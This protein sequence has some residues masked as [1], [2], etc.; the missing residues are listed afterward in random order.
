[1]ALKS[2]AL[3]PGF[4]K[5]LVSQEKNN[6]C[7]H[8]GNAWIFSS[9]SHSKRNCNK[10]H[11]MGKVWEIDTHTFP[12]AW[13]LFSIEIPILCYNSSYGKCMG[14]PISFS[15]YGKM[16]QNPSYGENLGSW[17]PYFS[18]SMGA[19]YPL[20]FHPMVYFIIW[21]MHMFSHQ[22]PIAWEKTAK[23][24]EWGKPKKLVP[25]KILQNPLYVENLGIATHTFPIVWVLF[26]IIFPSY[27]IL[28]RMENAWVFLSNF[29]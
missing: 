1:M 23:S 14:F 20:D 5:Q 21:E 18:H 19:F 24:I 17:Y 28:H 27:G 9:I 8:I 4:S 29:P 7:H 2:G 3:T 15:N 22:F 11:G 26:P 16:Q 6:Q 12:I 13:V 10:T 25:S